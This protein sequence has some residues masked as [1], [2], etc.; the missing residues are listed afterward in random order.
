MTDTAMADQP[1]PA[2]SPLVRVVVL[3]YNGG[4]LTMACLRSLLAT[5]WPADRLEVVLVDN[6]SVDDVVARV[7]AELPAVV[8]VESPV[9]SGFAGGCNLGARAPGEWDLLAFVNNDAD[10]RAGL[11][12]SAGGGDRP[13][14]AGR[15]GVP[16][17]APRRPLR[18]GAR[19]RAGSSTG[20][21]AHARRAG[22]RGARRR[23]APRSTTSAFDEGFFP[24]GPPRAPATRSIGGRGA[25]ARC[26]C[27]RSA[28]VAVAVTP[29]P[30]PAGAGRRHRGDAAV[31]RRPARCRGRQ[32]RADVGRGRPRRSAVRRHQQRRR[33]PVPP[34]VLRRP[35]VPRS[36]T[37]VST[38][39]RQ[40]V[41]GFSGGAVVLARAMVDDVGLFDER[42]VPVLRGHRPRVARPTARLALRVRA[43][44]G[45][46]PPPRLLDGRR[47]T[48]LPLPHRAQPPAGAGQER[49]G[50]GRRAGRARRRRA[51]TTTI[52]HYVLRPSPCACRP[53]RRLP[54][55]GLCARDTCDCCPG[56]CAIV[57]RRG[58]PSP[59]TT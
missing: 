58:A 43:D 3:N 45:R 46:A 10:G 57:G 4:D 40:E 59:V 25:R 11:A 8:V 24:A 32:R 49:A 16:E 36:A 54:T 14:G 29:R 18:R 42:P 7:A 1:V 56:I 5:D 44:G 13:G 41:F 34:R 50:G 27:G 33:R 30:A 6:A 19:R 52:R 21:R 12:A 2:V 55:G 37:P 23:R 9:N 35:W 26:V 39:R 31:R 51:V 15:R 38:T 48:R 28:G 20:R 22:D 53:G 47:V 17:D